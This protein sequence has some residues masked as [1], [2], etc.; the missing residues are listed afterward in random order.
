MPALDLTEGVAVASVV[1]D[2]LAATPEPLVRFLG[3]LHDAGIAELQVS[4]TPLRLGA[5][6]DGARAGD[7]QRALH[8]AFMAN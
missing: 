4:A 2:G 1:G 3:A 8:A 5:V 7:A 6:V